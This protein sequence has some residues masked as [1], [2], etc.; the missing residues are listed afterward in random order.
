MNKW[1]IRGFDRVTED[2]GHDTFVKTHKSVRQRVNPCVNYGLKLII[3]YWHIS[4]NKCTTLNKT[5]ANTP[6]YFSIRH[7]AEEYKKQRELP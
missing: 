6:K 3:I 1:N 2:I 5:K 7:D 4:W